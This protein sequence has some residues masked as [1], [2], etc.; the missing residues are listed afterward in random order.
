MAG[1]ADR[2]GMAQNNSTG[3]RRNFLTPLRVYSACFVLVLIGYMVL[4]VPALRQGLL[5]LAA[6]RQNFELVRVRQVLAPRSVVGAG[7]GAAALVSVMLAFPAMR[8]E[9]R[10]RV[11]LREASMHA[12]LFLQCAAAGAVVL[13]LNWYFLRQY[14]K[15]AWSVTHEEILAYTL[16]QAWPDSKRVTESVP[17]TAR[18]AFRAPEAHLYWLPSQTYPLAYFEPFPKTTG[19]KDDAEFSAFVREKKLTHLLDYDTNKFDL[20]PLK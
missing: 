9:L 7:V 2:L 15:P 13:N 12:F 20:Q 11:G 8:R 19:W 18:I 16:P 1:V 14:K 10:R 6:H 5:S 17:P 3:E 4:R